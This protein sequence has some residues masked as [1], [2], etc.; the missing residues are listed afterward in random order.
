MIKVGPE[1]SLENYPAVYDFFDEQTISG[2]IANFAHN[3]FRIGYSPEVEYIGDAEQQI[4]EHFGEDGIAMLTSTHGLLDDP[5]VL[6]SIAKREK[7]LRPLVKNTVIPAKEAIFN[8]AKNLPIV[9][10]GVNKLMRVVLDNFIALPTF[11][12]RDYPLEEMPE[13]EREQTEESLRG[14]NSRLID[15]CVDSLDDEENLAIFP[16]G[17][18]G[19]DPD[20]IQE[21]KTG[22]IRMAR[23]TKNQDRLFFIPVDIRYR[24]ERKLRRKEGESKLAFTGRQISNLLKRRRPYV[25]I[26]EVVSIVSSDKELLKLVKNGLQECVYRTKEMEAAA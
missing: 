24:H 26:G 19:D 10:N 11:R 9:K 14:A 7:V 6:A 20:E 17:H 3:V 16:E 21:L 23:R 2:K 15:R 5:F 12:D 22:M 8:M 13:G 25:A 4:K 1:V 18:R